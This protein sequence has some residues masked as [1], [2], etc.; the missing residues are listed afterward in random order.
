MTEYYDEVE[1]ELVI[2]K[3]LCRQKSSKCEIIV[4]A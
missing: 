4:K 1:W 3:L 2:D